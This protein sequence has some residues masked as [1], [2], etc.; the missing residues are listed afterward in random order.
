M[1]DSS[2]AAGAAAAGSLQAAGASSSIE[3]FYEER[4]RERGPVSA[5]VMTGL[6]RDGTLQHATRV[7]RRGLAGWTPL[8]SSELARH[9]DG[10][11][12]VSLTAPGGAWT[13]LL[14]TSPVVAVILQ[15][16]AAGMWA[17]GTDQMRRLYDGDLM[18]VYQMWPVG[19]AY[20]TALAFAD[21]TYLGR[22]KHKRPWL[23]W[24][25]L[26]PTYLWARAARLDQRQA[27][28]AAWCVAFLASVFL[29]SGPH[30]P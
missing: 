4:G 14:A 19:I 12:P 17:A 8:M 15:M 25:P 24:L 13:W 3:W 16:I 1:S 10:P 23:V 7:W 30:L 2:V 28:F 11:P 27:P 6:I 29:G 5:E 20:I 21:W 22:G 18:L 9:L 26:T